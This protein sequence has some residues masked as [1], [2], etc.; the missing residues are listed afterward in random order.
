MSRVNGPVVIVS[1]CDSLSVYSHVPPGWIAGRMTV[2]ARSVHRMPQAASPAP[3]LA[4]RDRRV[5]IREVRLR[6]YRSKS[7]SRVVRPHSIQMTTRPNAA[8]V[9]PRSSLTNTRAAIETMALRERPS[10][11]IHEHR[12]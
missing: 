3:I 10:D 4:V 9:S 12:L 5:A 11:S 1:V 2:M 7:P 6:T 8:T